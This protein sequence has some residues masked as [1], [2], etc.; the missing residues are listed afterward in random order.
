MPRGLV[1]FHQAPTTSQRAHRGQ[2]SHLLPK[3]INIYAYIYIYTHICV[4]TYIHI[5]AYYMYH[6]YHICIYIHRMDV[7]DRVRDAEGVQA[8]IAEVGHKD[9][10]SAAGDVPE[11][12]AAELLPPG[13]SSKRSARATIVSKVPK[14]AEGNPFPQ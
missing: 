13:Q 8:I 12:R 2:T 11:G 10:S 4:Y 14:R 7:G 3:Y 9:S 5:Y 6:T 1:D